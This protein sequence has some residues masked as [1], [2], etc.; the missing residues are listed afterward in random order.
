MPIYIYIY[1]QIYIYM[2]VYVYITNISMYTHGMKIQL[3][4]V[5]W[6]D[7]YPREGGRDGEWRV[8]GSVAPKIRTSGIHQRQ[9]RTCIFTR[10][11]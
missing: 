5:G 9:S 1:T 7:R 10:L 4:L 3:Q 11:R 2:Y 6:K 8:K